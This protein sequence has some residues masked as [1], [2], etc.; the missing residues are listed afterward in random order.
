M[1]THDWQPIPKLYARYRCSLCGAV[2]RRERL[3]SLDPF[4]SEAIEAYPCEAVRGFVKCGAPAVQGLQRLLF[5]CAEHCRRPTA[6]A[7]QERSAANGAQAATTR[8]TEEPN[9]RAAR[10]D[11]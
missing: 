8:T 4:E 11:A 10:G 1:C 9:T 5:R 7:R 6:R 2:G 3:I